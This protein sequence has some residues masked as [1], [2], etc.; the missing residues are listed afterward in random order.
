MSPLPIIAISEAVSNGGSILWFAQAAATG[1]AIGHLGRFGIAELG[2]FGGLALSL[3]IKKDTTL[4]RRG[5]THLTTKVGAIH[6]DIILNA[7]RNSAEHKLTQEG[8]ASFRTHVETEFTQL[9][10]QVQSVEDQVKNGFAH[11]SNQLKAVET[12]LSRQISG[13]KL[14]FHK[15]L[16]TKKDVRHLIVLQQRHNKQVLERMKALEENQKTGNFGIS[17]LTQLF[18]SK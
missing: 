3:G 12:N 11:Q 6:Q 1:A 15:G 5:I 2:I 14:K 16:A 10:Q 8:I 9:K 17:T 18:R 13:L 7:M 4:I